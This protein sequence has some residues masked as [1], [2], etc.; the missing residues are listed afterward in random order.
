MFGHRYFGQ[1]YFGGR[2]WGDGGT[3]I[4]PE[5]P[6]PPEVSRAAGGIVR[7]RRRRYIMP[8]GTMIEATT[9]EA[10]D[11]L[12][13]YSVPAPVPVVSKEAP[14]RAFS[15]RAPAVVLEKSDVR[16][17]PAT[18]SAPDTWKAVLDNQFTFKAPD[19]M[20]ARVRAARMRQ[21]EDEMIALFL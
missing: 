8:D 12:R 11:W 9:Q 13:A 15:I 2:Y 20:T 4:P 3:G 1:R 18:D 6:V 10:F 21:E 17:I 16:F 5:P 7:G 14:R 19:D